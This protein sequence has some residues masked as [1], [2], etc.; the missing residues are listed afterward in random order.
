MKEVTYQEPSGGKP[1][2]VRI[3][4]PLTG[5]KYPAHRDKILTYAQQHGADERVME[6]LQELDSREFNDLDDLLQNLN[7]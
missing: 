3:S 5:M 6:T 1:S 4:D 7:L 2:P